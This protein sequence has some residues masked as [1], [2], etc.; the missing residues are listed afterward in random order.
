MSSDE[1]LQGLTETKALIQRITDYA[2]EYSSILKKPFN[3]PV[4]IFG[5]AAWI[6]AFIKTGISHVLIHYSDKLLFTPFFEPL[7]LP[8][9]VDVL[10]VA[11]DLVVLH[12]GSFLWL[13]ISLERAIMS[14]RL[15][16]KASRL[17]EIQAS[18]ES[19]IKQLT[20]SFVPEDYWKVTII[21]K[22]EKYVMNQRASTLKEC[23]NLYEQERM[24]EE[25]VGRLEAAESAANAARAEA[26]SAR[27][28]ASRLQSEVDD[29]N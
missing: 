11:T 25:V 5:L 12:V 7:N 24:H 4:T 26:A 18:L 13:S 14:R 8:Q 27:R 3:L 15:C 21:E 22:L 29:L 6:Y 16:V 19:A 28:E 1:L 23:L 9:N 17:T 10:L 2:E 20:A